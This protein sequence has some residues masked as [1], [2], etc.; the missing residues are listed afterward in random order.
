MSQQPQIEPFKPKFN[1]NALQIEE[2]FRRR[3]IPA[4]LEGFPTVEIFH[5]LKRLQEQAHSLLNDDSK[6]RKKI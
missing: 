4:S 2:Y 5:N 6:Y 3:E 1:K